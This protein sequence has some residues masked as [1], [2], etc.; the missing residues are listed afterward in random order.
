MGVLYATLERVKRAADIS[1]TADA[2]DQV[3][4]ALESA[5]R[6][7]DGGARVGDGLLGR[8]FYPELAT[9]YIPILST[10][11]ASALPLGD[12]E[13]AGPPT[14]VVSG[15]TTIA[16]GAG[17]YFLEP[18][19]GPP[20][21]KLQLD[22][23]T[24][25]AWPSPGVRGV[26]VT[27]P[28][29][30]R[31]DESPVGAL[32][33]ALDLTETDVEVTRSADIGVGTI[34]RTDTERMIV[35]GRAMLTT[36]VTLGADL[37]AY[38][39]DQR[40]SVASGAA[41]GSGETIIIDAETMLITAVVGN[42]LV[43]RRAWDGS[44][45]DGHLTGATIYAPRLLTVERGALGTTAATHLISAPLFRHVVPGPVESLCVAET[46]NMLGQEDGAYARSVAAG[47]G[48]STTLGIGLQD[49]R[50]QAVKALRRRPQWLGV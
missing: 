34:L 14:L 11:A 18:Q 42:I 13:L 46:L 1:S 37:T 26:A 43:V 3:L 23:A 30:Y 50:N 35:T 29:G 32:A 4:R 19:E 6:S 39:N 47:D 21:G 41:F 45:L 9:R 27:G 7:I 33:E 12:Y 36:G 38:N 40:V 10:H 5:S 24:I 25:G 15:V 20:Y 17:G 28:W 44:T 2:D 16:A 31:L 49:I 8:R 22:T 48:L